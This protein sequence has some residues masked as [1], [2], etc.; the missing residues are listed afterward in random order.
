MIIS[1]KK[2]NDMMKLIEDSSNLILRQNKMIHQMQEEIKQQEKLIGLYEACIN[3]GIK[4]DFPDVTG[5]RKEDNI[6]GNID[7]SDF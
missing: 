1:Q 3:K 7:F 2:Y 4:V 6:S 5:G